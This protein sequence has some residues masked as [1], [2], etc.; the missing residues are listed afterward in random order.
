MEQVADRS[1]KTLGELTRLRR[2]VSYVKGRN[3]ALKKALEGTSETL[4][5]FVDSATDGFLLLDSDLNVVDVQRRALST[6]GIRADDVFGKSLQNL[7]HRLGIDPASLRFKR[8]KKVLTTEESVVIDEIRVDTDKGPM[9]MTVKMFK[10]GEGVGIVVTFIT[11]RKLA[12]DVLRRSEAQ[13]RLLSQRIIKVQEEERASIARELH[14]QLGQE[15]AALKIEVVSI[16]EKL[17]CEPAFHERACRLLTMVERLDET[18]H[19]IAV[20]IR[21]QEL[22]QLGLIR[23]IN[24]YAEDFERRTGISCP[25]DAP[26]DE[27]VLPKPVATCAYRIV[28]EA[29]TNVLKHSRASQAKV[30]VRFKDGIMSVSVSDNGIGVDFKHLPDA[31]SLGLLGMRERAELSGGKLV[32]RGR[33][34]KGLQVIARLPVQDVHFQGG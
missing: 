29:L 12:E 34:G 3:R 21:P 5:A 13:L 16:T 2:Q 31:S 27:V 26:A 17:E 15:L 1:G 25:V 24:L 18:T 23:A 8:L 33:P 10:V 30:N 14:D 4:R 32:L 19:R 7:L 28:Q 11:E 22:D 6:F 9:W 20:S